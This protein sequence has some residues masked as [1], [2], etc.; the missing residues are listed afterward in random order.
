M[1]IIREPGCCDGWESD[2]SEVDGEC[3]ECGMKTVDG[4]AASG[5]CF[6]LVVC[7]TCKYA[8]CDGSC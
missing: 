2:E 6:S 5:C 1:G 3:P 4:I 7:G 8:P